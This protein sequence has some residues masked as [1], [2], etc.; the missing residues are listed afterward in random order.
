MKSLFW[1][2]AASLLL[3]ACLQGGPQRQDAAA[4]PT[5]GTQASPTATFPTQGSVPEPTIF[6]QPTNTPTSTTTSV[7]TPSATEATES[8][9][10]PSATATAT[11]SASPTLSAVSCNATYCVSPAC[12]VDF[13]TDTGQAS[14]AQAAAETCQANNE[15]IR[16]KMESSNT[17][18]IR[19][20][21]R[22]DMQYAG[23]T[24]GNLIEL[25]TTWFTEHPE[26]QGAI[27]HEMA[28]VHQ[29]Y[30]GTN[31]PFWLVEGIADYVRYW[32]GYA[33]SWSYAHCASGSAHYTSGYWCS[34]AF[35]N[36]VEKT[37]DAQL[38]PKLNRDLRSGQ[39]AG[40]WFQDDTTQTA[41]QLWTECLQAD[42]RSTG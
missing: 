21:L 31:P 19:I 3:C 26:D 16:L 10:N 24:S 12:T 29:G 6:E 36:Y 20:V 32:S 18:T 1:L 28:H 37:Y 22:S 23:Q 30:T 14:F 9:P 34:A 11:A 25:S 13:S 35:L 5:I 41:D 27:V 15:K 39:Y 8:T 17:Q 38:I 2:V 7:P 33:N 42:C 40:S 4:L